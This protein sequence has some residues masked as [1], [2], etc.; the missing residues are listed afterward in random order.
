LF[1][2][3]RHCRDD[4]TK[5]LAISWHAANGSAFDDERV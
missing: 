3:D 2:Q 5:R 4:E 1:K